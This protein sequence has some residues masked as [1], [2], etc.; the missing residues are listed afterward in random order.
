M[1]ASTFATA[2]S[3]TSADTTSAEATSAEAT[4]ADATSADATS[5]DATSADATSADATSAEATSADATSA[6]ATSAEATSADADRYI[7]IDV[8]KDKLAVS[9]SERKLRKQVKNSKTQ[10]IKFLV[11]KIENHDRTFV[12]CEATGGYER[13]L[14]RE[15]QNAGIRIHVANP[16]QV[17]H[18]GK[19]LGLLEKTDPIDAGVLMTFARVVDLHPT[20]QKTP[21]HERHEALVRRRE[22]VLQLISQ[23]QNRLD[24]AEEPQIRKLIGKTLKL[25]RTQL[26]S[27]DRDIESML[28]T[29]AKTNPVVG[30]LQSVPGVGTVTTATLLCELPE[31]GK[32]NRNE[33]AKLAGVAPLAR[34]SGTRDR[35]RLTQGGR[36]QV[37]RVLYMAALVAA[38]H[39]P[40]IRS[41]YQRLLARGKNKKLALVACMR[42]LLGI[43]NTMVKNGEPWRRAATEQKVA[44]SA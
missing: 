28:A 18:F 27:L 6:D 31:L 20:P 16:A 41:F 15:L 3:A 23:E 4:S 43:L 9:D 17:R 29:L 24:Q 13:T 12:V 25:F 38:R 10:I 19:G 34:Q 8:D 26:Q 30:I 42:K 37:R 33:A 21:Q 22:Q 11:R 14:V 2:P 44:A 40:V 32:L 35:K 39:N 1:T 7:G 36:P 5:A